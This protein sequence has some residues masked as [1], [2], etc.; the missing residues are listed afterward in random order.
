[1][2][3]G[4]R[5]GPGS[6]IGQGLLALISKV[7]TWPAWSPVGRVISHF[8]SRER[9]LPFRAKRQ[10]DTP[11]SVRGTLVQVD[12]CDCGNEVNMHVI[13]LA[14]RTRIGWITVRWMNAP[15]MKPIAG[16]R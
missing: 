12:T 11:A 9:L 13:R 5:A 6:S 4:G 14:A 1:M 16:P 10:I 3:D 15:T 7:L 2:S 8:G